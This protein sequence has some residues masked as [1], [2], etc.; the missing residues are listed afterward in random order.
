MATARASS[1]TSAGLRAAVSSQASSTS[2]S[3]LRSRPGA[4]AAVE[5]ASAVG[6]E[7]ASTASSEGPAVASDA[8]PY[9]RVA[10]ELSTALRPA[11]VASTTE[12]PLNVPAALHHGLGPKP[13]GALRACPG[14][15]P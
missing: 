14:A 5:I 15:Q 6:V 9:R 10:A 4:A 2:A 8:P 7:I 12:A 1:S 13:P 3:G 11:A